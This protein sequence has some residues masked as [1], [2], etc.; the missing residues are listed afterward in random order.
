ML[1]LVGENPAYGIRRVRGSHI[2]VPRL[3]DHDCAYILQ[4]P[5]TRICFATPTAPAGLLAFPG[6]LASRR[7]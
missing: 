2:V 1:W 7:S 4:Q 3:F 5:D 6:F